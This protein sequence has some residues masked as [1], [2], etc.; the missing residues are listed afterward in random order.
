MNPKSNVVFHAEC[1]LAA[2]G[3]TPVDQ[4]QED[5]PDKWIQ[6]S[7]LELLEVFA[8]Q[9]HSGFSGPYCIGLF[10]KLAR[11]EPLSPLTGADEEWTEVSDGLWQNKRC[12]HVFKDKEGRAYDIEGVVFGE[13]NGSSFLSNESRVFVTFPYTPTKKYVDL[14]TPEAA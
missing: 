7:V 2:I 1:E 4:P 13:S 11:F 14:P 8:R 10:C 5:G 6:E 12:S 3:Y 9:G